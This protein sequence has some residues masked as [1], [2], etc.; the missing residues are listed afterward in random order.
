MIGQTKFV[1][2]TLK[3]IKFYLLVSLLIPQLLFARTTQY[4]KMVGVNS[5]WRFLKNYSI[6]F[7][8]LPTEGSLADK[9]W[10]G[11]YWADFLG[12]TT[13]RWYPLPKSKQDKKNPVRFGYSLPTPEEI[14][15][16]DLR[17][18]SPA[19]KYDLYMGDSNWTITKQERERT[20]VLKTIKGTS[21]YDPSF[22]VEGWWGLC[23]A[24]A[25]AT[26]LYKNPA[27]ITLKNPQGIKIPFG[28]SDIKALLSLHMHTVPERSS[29]YTFLG[30]RCFT[31]L[32]SIF[33]KWAKFWNTHSPGADEAALRELQIKARE[34]LE[35]EL[36][37]LKECNDMNPGAFHVALG[38]S[39]GHN[40]DGFVMDKDRGAETWNQG[41]YG[42]KVKILKTRNE[43]VK[44]KPFTVHSIENTVTW[45]TEIGHS[46]KKV[47]G[48]IGLTTTKYIYDLYLDENGNI[49]GGKW[50]TQDLMDRPDIIWMRRPA[51]KFERGLKGLKSIYAA[52]EKESSKRYS[53]AE[54]K[55]LFKKSAKKVMLANRFVKNSKELV[56]KRKE[57]RLSYYERLKKTVVGN[58]FSQMKERDE[59]DKRILAS[60]KP[61]LERAR[62]RII[63]END[64]KDKEHKKNR[65]CLYSLVNWKGKLRKE[66]LEKNRGAKNCKKAR[67]RCQDNKRHRWETCY[68]GNAKDYYKP[69]TFELLSKKGKPLGKFTENGAYGEFNCK[70]SKFKCSVRKLFVRRC[71]K[72]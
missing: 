28:A 71:V 16:M 32:K 41:V 33:G 61:K 22:K 21:S 8:E 39:I 38:N 55:S 3:E 67:S 7:D 69:C 57:M 49:K 63:R 52:S 27:P 14:K 6:K 64:L 31:D 4:D 34:G 24:W 15:K 56:K 42:Y 25:P 19:E 46:W 1:K 70:V 2:R 20:G 26:V 47:K 18:L 40:K 68:Y 50:L 5:P 10:S 59:R 45:V 53:K 65:P 51:P 11:D 23:H 9:P 17:T 36:K 35:N 43:K 62:K 54:L 13:Y 48:G 44:D 12:G 60:L 37:G 72:R 30:D 29:E 58:F 66:F